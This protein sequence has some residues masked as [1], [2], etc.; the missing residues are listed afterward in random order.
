MTTTSSRCGHSNSLR[1]LRGIAS[2]E[3]YA[4]LFLTL[5]NTL[6]QYTWPT[7][8][9]SHRG[10]VPTP[11]NIVLPSLNKKLFLHLFYL[12][13]FHFLSFYFYFNS[14][15]FIFSFRKLKK[16]PRKFFP[17]T[18]YIQLWIGKESKVRACF[19]PGSAHCGAFSPGLWTW[20]A[21][22][23]PAII[24]DINKTNLSI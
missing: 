12:I 24:G 6:D 16:I 23:G 3:C 15:H 8:K 11:K 7:H 13:P 10:V 1:P 18:F 14:F 21:G 22:P 19:W 9:A 5:T 2:M 17:F 20:R 4:F